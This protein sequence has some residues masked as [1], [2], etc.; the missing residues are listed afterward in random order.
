MFWLS[1]LI[2]ILYDDVTSIWPD[3]GKEKYKGRKS[4]LLMSQ[5]DFPRSN[6]DQR[7]YNIRNE[8]VSESLLNIWI[9]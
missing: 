9:R 5:C 4:G 3:E 6:A 1:Y 2:V 7:V 8:A